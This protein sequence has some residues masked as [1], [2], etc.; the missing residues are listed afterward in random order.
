MKDGGYYMGSL[1]NHPMDGAF[2]MKTR[3]WFVWEYV[4]FSYLRSNQKDQTKIHSIIAKYNY[5]VVANPR[6]AVSLIKNEYVKRIRMDSLTSKLRKNIEL[7]LDITQNKY[8]YPIVFAIFEA[9]CLISDVDSQF[10]LDLIKN[11]EIDGETSEE[12]DR[13]RYLL[14]ELV[15]HWDY[16]I[17]NYIN[18]MEIQNKILNKRE[19]LH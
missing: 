16:V 2:P 5:F 9:K 11:S 12:K 4:V 1:L 14:N 10:F 15:T 13:R 18:D 17:E 6:K 19:A 8:T 3:D 7:M